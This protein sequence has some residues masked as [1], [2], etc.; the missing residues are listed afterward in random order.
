[1]SQTTA[2]ETQDPNAAALPPEALSP[3][4]L[5]RLARRVY[6]LLRDDLARQRERRGAGLGRWR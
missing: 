3:R 1:M 5:E 2:S 6:E 4:A